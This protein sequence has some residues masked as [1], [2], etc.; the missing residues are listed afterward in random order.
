MTGCCSTFAN[1][2]VLVFYP[3]RDR[4]SVTEDPSEFMIFYAALPPPSCLRR[5]ASAALP[6]PCSIRRAASDTIHPKPLYKYNNRGG[7]IQQVLT[8]GHQVYDKRPCV[9]DIEISMC[10][11]ATYHQMFQADML[12]FCSV[13]EWTRHFELGWSRSQPSSVTT[14]C[15]A[16]TNDLLV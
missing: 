16:L 5:A 2:Y 9:A 15:H 4:L 7:N 1:K 13:D 12:K 3:I 10:H 11:Q 8:C 6:P 14:L